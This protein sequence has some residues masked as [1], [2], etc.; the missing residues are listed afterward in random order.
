V[1]KEVGMPQKSIHFPDSRFTN[2]HLVLSISDGLIVIE[3]PNGRGAS[4]SAS[5]ICVWF[6]FAFFFL[7]FLSRFSLPLFCP[8]R[9]RLSYSSEVCFHSFF[10]SFLVFF[11]FFFFRSD[12]SP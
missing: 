12:T 4:I 5:L 10:F 6:Q 7:H 1:K 11:V 2:R 3:I 9:L 8:S